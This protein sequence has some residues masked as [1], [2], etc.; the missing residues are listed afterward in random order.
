MAPD[1]PEKLDMHFL[2]WIWEYPATRRPGVLSLL[3]EFSLGRRIYP[4]RSAREV[5]SFLASLKEQH[6]AVR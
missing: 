4:L 3:E 6:V 5:S 2:K 1:C